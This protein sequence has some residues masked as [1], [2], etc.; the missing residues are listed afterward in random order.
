MYSIRLTKEIA[1]G[2][3]TR[4]KG[5]HLGMSAMPLGELIG[6]AMSG[7]NATLLASIERCDGVIPCEII[8]A[9]TNAELV[10]SEEPETRRVSPPPDH[11]SP[12]PVTQVTEP[13]HPLPVERLAVEPRIIA[14]LRRNN[15]LTLLDLHAY[16][17]ANSGLTAING[18]GRATEIQLAASLRE[19]IKGTNHVR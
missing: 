5:S 2:N 17:E 9:L 7:D 3:G 18:I 15:I 1:L 10:T 6:I 8:T 16:A 12:D 4:P 14:I 19:I 11:A 13:W